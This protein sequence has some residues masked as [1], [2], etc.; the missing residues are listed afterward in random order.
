MPTTRLTRTAIALLAVTLALLLEWTR[1]PLLNRLDEGIRDVIVRHSADRL[2]ETR[3]AVV[4]IDDESIRRLGPWPWPRSRLADLLELLISQ[5]AVRSI[6]LDVALPEA[7]EAAGDARLAAMAHHAPLT[8]AQ[9]LDYTPRYPSLEL[10]ELR[11]GKPVK[12]KALLRRQAIGHIGLHAGLRGARCAGNIGYQPDADGVLR[13]LPLI[14]RYGDHEYLHLGPAMLECSQESALSPGLE[15]LPQWRIPYHKDLSAYTVIPAHLILEG[16]TPPDLLQGRWLLVGSSSLGLGD[17]VS[18]P[19]SPISA[20]I[21]VHAAT[22]SALLD[23]QA[24]D[25]RAPWSG[26]PWMVAWLLLSTTLATLF[27]GRSRAWVGVLGLL[28]L[29]SLW[30]LQA[31]IG[32]LHQAEW[33]IT[34]P[35]WGM[36]ILLLLGIPHEWRL[37]Q[38]KSQQAIATLGH[39][40]SSQVLD[41]ILRRNLQYSLQPTLREVTVLIA[42]IEGYTRLTSSLSLEEAAQLT[43]GVLESLTSP[44]LAGGGT[45]DKYSGDGLV[46]FWGAPLDCPDQADMAIG[47]ALAMLD[48]IDSFNVHEAGRLPAVRIRIGIESG[49][50]LVGD[51]GTPFRSTYTAVGDC[52]NFASRLESAARDYPVPI[53]IGPMANARITRFDTHRVGT[54]NLRGTNT[55]LDIFSLDRKSATVDNIRLS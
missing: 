9:I 23:L 14:T 31:G 53:L 12:D 7:G 10:G 52:I 17:R 33:S 32:A 35:L 4:D 34:A 2:P 30:L 48:A 47:T 49:A 25:L 22:L 37:A 43:K 19:L 55:S 5:H 38:K 13:H 6:A 28:L 46:A 45:L 41:E 20:G 11:G 50:A 51:L 24:G 1:P 27:I 54:I 29:S 40:V 8:L 3:I 21:M 42:D 36:L 16:Q 39:Y 18:T 26:R 44:L 15:R